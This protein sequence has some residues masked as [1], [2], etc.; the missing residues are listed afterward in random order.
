M[1]Y[2]IPSSP[3]GS[4]WRSTTNHHLSKKNKKWNHPKKIA[5]TML[6]KMNLKKEAHH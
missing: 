6:E 1:G 4:F 5:K 3:L 2:F